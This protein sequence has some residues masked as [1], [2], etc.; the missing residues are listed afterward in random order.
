MTTDLTT[1]AIRSTE[2]QLYVSRVGRRIARR[3]E[4]LGWSQRELA[5][6]VGYSQRM[7][8][9]WEDGD[10]MP[11]VDAQLALASILGVA[12]DELFAFA[13]RRGER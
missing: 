3:R 7:I 10:T 6:R 9:F 8:G 1:R 12:P 11:R 13:R 2:G 5:R 4:A